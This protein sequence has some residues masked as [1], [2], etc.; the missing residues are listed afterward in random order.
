MCNRMGV[1]KPEIKYEGF[2]GGPLLVRGLGGPCPW[3]RLGGIATTTF[4]PRSPPWSRYAFLRW[5]RCPMR[6]KR[7]F[8]ASNCH[9]FTARRVVQVSI[10]PRHV[11]K[12]STQAKLTTRHLVQQYLNLPFTFLWCQQYLNAKSN[13][14][15]RSRTY[16]TRVTVV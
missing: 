15:E 1:I 10:A 11:T 6:P 7:Y 8:V 14:S 13:R 16:P 12:V 4:W 9:V 2:G 3:G 5:R